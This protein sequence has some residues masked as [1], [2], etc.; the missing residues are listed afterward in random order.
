MK[1]YT[2]THILNYQK[3]KN[4]CSESIIA[5]G[6]TY[7]WQKSAMEKIGMHCNMPA[8]LQRDTLSTQSPATRCGIASAI[9]LKTKKSEMTQTSAD[10]FFTLQIPRCKRKCILQKL[11][12]KSRKRPARSMQNEPYAT[13]SATTRF[14]LFL[15]WLTLQPWRWR[16][17]VPPKH[18]AST[19]LHDDTAQK[20]VPFM[21]TTMR[22]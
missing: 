18:W 5:S 9:T 10:C 11:W 3:E 16:Q 2:K 1:Y 22:T 12:V 13:C 19:G 6:N 4:M 15:A 20:T 17:Y 7:V 21:V 8:G 14:L